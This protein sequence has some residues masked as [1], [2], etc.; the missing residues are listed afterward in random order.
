M[1]SLKALRNRISVVE[2]TGQ[3]TKAM[4]A[5]SVSKLRR[6]QQS[7]ENTRRYADA[8]AQITGHL[9][10]ASAAVDHPLQR[11]TET[12]GRFTAV[13]MTSDRGMCGAYNN[14]AI[15]TLD[16]YVSKHG[17]HRVE[18]VCVGKKG[19]DHCRKKGYTILA[20]HIDLGGAVQAQL[21]AELTDLLVSRFMA[22]ETDRVVIIY[23]SFINMMKYEQ[24]VVDILPL[25]PKGL[26]SG[27]DGQDRGG[28]EM[29]FEPDASTVF[30]VVLERY[31][32]VRVVT[33]QADALTAEHSARM[34][35]MSNA[36]ENCEEL[37]TTLTLQM[38]KARQA[39]IT[40]ELLEI[41]SGAEALKG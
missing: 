21:M 8:L 25:D 10:Q 20:A 37:R 9:L 30:S 11:S 12:P 22:R 13:L 26:L 31:L 36:T 28:G 29:I 24:K 23:N 34:I 18:V 41:V 35:A 16:A 19:R 38:N 32:R 7:M 39:S 2:N 27:E 14:H 6:V 33:S 17:A 3:I 5:V 15:S 40:K 4:K 1:P